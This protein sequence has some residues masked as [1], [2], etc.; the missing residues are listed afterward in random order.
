MCNFLPKMVFLPFL[1]AILNI[2]VKCKNA[3]ILEMVRDTAISMKFLTHRVYTESPAIICQKSFY[4]HFLAA[5]LN[6]CIK[7]KKLIILITVQDRAISAISESFTYFWVI[8]HMV[9]LKIC[10][11][12]HSLVIATEMSK[13]L[14]SLKVLLI[15]Y[16]FKISHS[17][18]FG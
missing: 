6:F 3:F 16:F 7:C 10:S 18:T 12:L 4:N 8:Y 14:L 15:C 1:T 17:P 11:S 5:I 2:C 9:K 13:C